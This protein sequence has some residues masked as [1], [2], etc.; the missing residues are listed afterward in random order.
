MVGETHELVHH[1]LK[2]DL[3]DVEHTPNL[4]NLANATKSKFSKLLFMGARAF[5]HV[6]K[7][8]DALFIYAFPTTNVGSQQHEIFL[9]T[10]ITRMCLERKM[11]TLYQNINHM[12]A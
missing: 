5:I 8:G 7:K 2:D 6:T 3:G 10:K 11:L 1:V 12:I 9:N 4:K